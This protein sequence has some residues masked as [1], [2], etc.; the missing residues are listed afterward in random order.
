MQYRSILILIVCIAA[1]AAAGCTSLQGSTAKSAIAPLPAESGGASTGYSSD[2]ALIASGPISR[3]SV[4]PQEE[5]GPG[6]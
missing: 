2:Q 4:P 1:V 5:S 6:R 3:R